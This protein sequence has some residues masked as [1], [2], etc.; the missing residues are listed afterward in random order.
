MDIKSGT[1]VFYFG[2]RIK[3]NLLFLNKKKHP[4]DVIEEIIDS[5]SYTFKR[6]FQDELDLWISSSRSNFRI[7]FN[8]NGKLEGIHIIVFFETKLLC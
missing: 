1:R 4:L 8:W 2:S 3:V 7:N 5:Q 6:S